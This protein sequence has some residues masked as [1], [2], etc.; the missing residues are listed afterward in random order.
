MALIRA[1]ETAK[2]PRQ[3]LFVDPYAQRFLPGWQRALMIP[4][5]LPIWRRLVEQ[6]APEYGFDE[7]YAQLL[8]TEAGSL[9][10]KLIARRIL[11]RIFAT[12]SAPQHG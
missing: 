7:L 1:L 5:L 8:G 6:L 3:R 12:Q 11:D 9:E 4:A 2:P 10:S